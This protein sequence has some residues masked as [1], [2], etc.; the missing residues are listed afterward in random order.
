MI[1]KFR[2]WIKEQNRM[3]KVFGF[4]EVFIFEQTWDSPSIKENIFEIENSILMQSTG[5]IDKNGIEIFQNDLLIDRETDH[6]GNDISSVMPVIYNPKQGAWC[7]DNSFK[8]DGSSL[9]S[10]V[11]YFGL[12]NLEVYGNI[13]QRL[14]L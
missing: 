3:I 9:V 4:N 11:D 6:E 14:E 7:I 10:M 1:P 12:E 8:K 2:S 5:I 13:Y